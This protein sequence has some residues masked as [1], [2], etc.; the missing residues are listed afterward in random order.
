MKISLIGTGYM[1]A[2]MAEQLIEAGNKLGVY[3]RTYKKAEPLGDKGAEVF[4]KFIDAIEFSDT[5]IFMLSDFFAINALLKD[6]DLSA[7]KDKTVIQ[8]ST[9]APDESSALQTRIENA[10]GEYFE[11]PVLG[12]IPQIKSKS[13]IVLV[14]STKD[15]FDK[16]KDLFHAF[17]GDVRHI[18]EVTKAAAIKLALNQLIVGITSVFSMSLGFVRESNIDV[19]QFMDIVRNS[20]LYAPTY[21]KKLE[22]YLSG[23]FS[24]PNFPLKHLLKD[25]NLMIDAFLD[26]Q[27]NIETLKG[28]HKVLEDGINEGLG[29][30]DYS[31]L[32][33]VI[34]KNS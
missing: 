24:N 15:Q 22:N 19:E 12:S 28:I 11:A 17:S 16:Y 5:L 29:E 1:G 34:H 25:L 31:S 4:D 18:G 26:K 30:L 8:M 2:P 33:K 3:N 32:Y 23:D 7:V 21:D 6:V 10:G 20:A 9:I 13:L 27:I 14:G